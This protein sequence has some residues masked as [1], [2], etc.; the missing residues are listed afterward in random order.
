MIVGACVV[1]LH[2]HGCRSLKAKRGV[3]R[4]IV[5]RV[6]NRFNLSVAEVGGQDTWQWAVLGLAAAGGDALRIRQV[7][8]QASDF[9][10]DLHLAEVRAVDFELV[11]LPQEQPCDDDDGD[12]VGDEDG[13]YDDGEDPDDEEID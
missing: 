12:C 2:I 3:V 1:E 6:R 7:L 10:E 4:S 5:R 8:E 11:D 13:V 9:I